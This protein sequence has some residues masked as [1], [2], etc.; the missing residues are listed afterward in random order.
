MHGTHQELFL[1]LA[2]HC[3][4]NVS[5]NYTRSHV[6]ILRLVLPIMLGS[7][8]VINCYTEQVFPPWRQSLTNNIGLDLFSSVSRS[9]KILRNSSI[10]FNFVATT[11]FHSD[12]NLPIFA[13]RYDL[14]PRS[15]CSKIPQDTFN[16]LITRRSIGWFVDDQTPSGR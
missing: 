10:R 8:C 6:G 11:I 5:Q 1:S 15:T 12:R 14:T 4:W 16:V 13:S 2:F 9:D 7:T 3:R